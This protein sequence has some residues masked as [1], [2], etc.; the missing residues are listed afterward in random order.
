MLASGAS[1]LSLNPNLEYMAGHSTC[2]KQWVL[3][4]DNASRPTH[5][6]GREAVVG[7][8]HYSQ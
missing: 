5:R 1:G 7:Q 8:V 2:Q 4:E 6:S 3:R